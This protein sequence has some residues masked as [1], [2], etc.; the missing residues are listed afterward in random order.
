ME[1]EFVI[2][3]KQ[4]ISAIKRAESAAIRQCGGVCRHD[5]EEVIDYLTAVAQMKPDSGAYR[6]LLTLAL[7]RKAANWTTLKSRRTGRS[8]ENLSY[9]DIKLQCPGGDGYP[10]LDNKPGY[11]NTGFLMPKC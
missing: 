7:W 11:V 4:A 5:R 2:L 9:G 1:A 10:R 8:G 6:N 3:S